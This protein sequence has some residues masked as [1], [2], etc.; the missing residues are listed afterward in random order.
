MKLSLPHIKSSNSNYVQT[1]MQRSVLAFG[2]DNSVV[3]NIVITIW[4]LL[5]GLVIR[6]KVLMFK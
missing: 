3:E 6:S 5:A 1:A 4:Q 2:R